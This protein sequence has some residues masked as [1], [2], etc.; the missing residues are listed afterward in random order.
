MC[1]QNCNN[2]I[3]SYTCN[4]NIGYRLNADGRRCDG[5]LLFYRIVI[6][7]KFQL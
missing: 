2:T 6:T 4:C 1:A 7:V 3:G 5:M